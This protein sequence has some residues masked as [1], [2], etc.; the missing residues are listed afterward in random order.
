MSHLS[1]LYGTFTRWPRPASLNVNHQFIQP[2]KT[3]NRGFVCLLSKGDGESKTWDNLRSWLIGHAKIAML[4]K[5]LRSALHGTGISLGTWWIEALYLMVWWQTLINVHSIISQTP[6]L[7]PLSIP[8]SGRVSQHNN[9][10]AFFHLNSIALS[11][12]DYTLLL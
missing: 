8:I 7:W 3:M 10:G 1:K 9:R 2:L 11:W 6:P 5:N 12:L 4:E